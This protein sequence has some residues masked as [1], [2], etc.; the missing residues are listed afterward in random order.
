MNQII[1]S[2]AYKN[3][4]V[5]II[6]YF[7][8]PFSK[9]FNYFNIT[10]N[11]LTFFSFI[12]L[13]VG[14][15]ELINE[16]FL[17]F[18]LLLII[19]IILDFCDG[20]VARISKNSNKSQLRI[21][22]LSDVVKMSLLFLSFGILFDDFGFWILIFVTNSLYLFFSILH[23]STNQV[24][25][26]DLKKKKN[27]PIFLQFLKKNLFLGLLKASIPIVSNFNV[28]SLLLLFLILIKI[29]FLSYILYYY[30]LLFL[31]RIIK[32]SIFFSKQKKV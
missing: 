16:S 30:I 21:D 27:K 14:C 12:F 2:A 20:Q 9:F 24:N 22:H 31:Y 25:K 15:N 18:Y 7:C 28:G 5:W 17:N 10:P 6:S 23:A 13:V 32:L 3:F 26:A 11:I 1:T 29:E 4:L 8:L 19:S